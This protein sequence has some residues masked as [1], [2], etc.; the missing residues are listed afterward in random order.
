VIEIRELRDDELDFLG[1]M[2]YAALGWRPDTS[3]PSIDFVLAHPQ[4]VIFH[5]DWGRDGDVA[6]VA[7]QDG[8]PVGL[9]WYRLFTDAE[10][11]EGYVDEQTPDLAIAVVDGYRGRGVGRRLLE[12]MHERARLDGFAR[13]SLSVDADNPAKRLYARLGYVEH[14][15][16]DGDGRMILDL[17]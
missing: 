9:V 4:V 14:E 6:L 11:G 15:P 10:H 3:L 7:E 13:I 2:L 16:D 8:R 12:A 1:E 5:R 17:R